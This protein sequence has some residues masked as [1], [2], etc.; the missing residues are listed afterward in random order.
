MFRASFTATHGEAYA[1]RSHLRTRCADEQDPEGIHPLLSSFEDVSPFESSRQ[2]SAMFNGICGGRHPGHGRH[3]PAACYAAYAARS[4]PKDY[5]PSISSTADFPFD[6]KCLPGNA[7]VLEHLF[8]VFF[9]QG[10]IEAKGTFLPFIEETLEICSK[11][12]QVSMRTKPRVKTLV[13][14]RSSEAEV[15][16]FLESFNAK[17]ATL[18]SPSQGFIPNS[19]YSLDVES[20]STPNG[21]PFKVFTGE[22]D[23][24]VKLV[25]LSGSMPARVH[26]GFHRRRYDIVFPW[27]YTAMTPQYTADYFLRIS[28]NPLPSYWHSLF[29][30]LHGLGIGIGLRKDL[31]QLTAFISTCYQ[32]EN[33]SSPIEIKTVDLLVLLALCGYNCPKTCIS[34]INF[35]FTGGVIQ[36]GWQI[37]CGLGLWSTT[38][39]LR[40]ELS[41]YL[42]SEA[43]GVLNTAYIALATCLVHWF[44]TPTIASVVSRKT[45]DKFLAWF[46]RFMSTVLRGAEFTGMNEFNNGVDRVF[47]PKSLI[48]NIKYSEDCPPVFPV[49]A[50]ARC[51]PPW[52]NVTGGGCCSDQQALDHLILAFCPMLSSPGVKDHL[53][54]QSSLAIIDGFLTGRPSPSAA[55]RVSRE[56]GCR[57]DPASISIP[58][59]IQ[60]E[61][62]MTASVRAVYRRHRQEAAEDDPLKHLSNAQTMLLFVW[63]HPTIAISLFENSP[64]DRNFHPFE[65]DY[66]LLRPVIIALRGGDRGL[67]L[68]EFYVRLLERRQLRNAKKAA[69]VLQ[70]A[71]ER[72]HVP[73]Q[74]R[75]VARRL[76]KAKRKIRLL[77]A[78]PDLSS[79]LPPVVRRERDPPV[80]IEEIVVEVPR[81]GSE[82]QP[83]AEDDSHTEIRIVRF[84]TPS[85]AP[86]RHDPGSPT[87][88]L[89][90]DVLV[91]STP[92]WED[93]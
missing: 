56:L 74:K 77:S 15:K 12:R 31:E 65:N 89:Q 46:W 35:V 68:P 27:E 52:R 55:S 33:V 88:S 71:S 39:E 42:Q 40:H 26:L 50:L 76:D 69:R 59:L 70:L 34:V 53:R 66:D 72:I 62:M 49:E 13:F 58:Q 51:I 82:S 75:K 5:G 4:D 10:G 32:F 37:R 78:N 61:R 93:L 28:A 36:K 63:S 81:G 29:A 25:R 41:L 38:N 1:R 79:S 3:N 16:D 14:G 18:E 91:V 57:R 21:T 92:R 73:A 43:I 22:D 80:E 7:P 44:V 48:M 19:L 67:P 45:P 60:G 24:N 83:P 85:P 30:K 11:N 23:S 54:W 90:S 87:E 17:I 86:P 47:S 8:V 84:R 2:M 64:P 6:R 20:V 9:G